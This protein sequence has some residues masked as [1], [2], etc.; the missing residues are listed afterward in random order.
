MVDSRV[1][2]HTG[3][4]VGPLPAGVPPVVLVLPAGERYTV[5]MDVILDANADGSIMHAMHLLNDG[6][7]A[8][9]RTVDECPIPAA[10]SPEFLGFPWPTISSFRSEVQPTT[11]NFLGRKVKEFYFASENADSCYFPPPPAIPPALGSFYAESLIPS[12]LQNWNVG[13]NPT[14]N[15]YGRDLVGNYA[16]AVLWY[17]GDP[18]YFT[19]AHNAHIA[20]GNAAPPQL[21]SP[22]T[23]GWLYV[24]HLAMKCTGFTPEWHEFDSHI[25]QLTIL[26]GEYQII[27]GPSGPHNSTFS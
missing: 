25:L 5:E 19:A 15:H 23:C 14:N 21:V 24:Q 8:C 1:F 16:D 4:N 11:S 12:Q 27:R 17:Q 13:P 7:G 6:D 18:A 2:D 20:L 22:A 9:F 3:A 26:E 10:D